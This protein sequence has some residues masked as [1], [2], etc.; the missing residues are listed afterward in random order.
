MG[1]V[2]YV[3]NHWNDMISSI[4]IRPWKLPNVEKIKLCVTL[5]EDAHY[6]GRSRR[7][8]NDVHW[9]SKSWNDEV[10]SLKLNCYDCSVIL[11]EHMKHKGNFK[12]FMDDVS[13]VGKWWNDRT[14]SIKLVHGRHPNYEGSCVDPGERKAYNAILWIP[15]FSTV[16]SL[17]SSAV[18]GGKGCD[19]VAKE[20]AIDMGIWFGD[21]HSSSANRGRCWS[22]SE[23][24]ALGGFSRKV[25]I[26]YS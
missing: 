22:R 12:A 10:S 14:S 2:P 19:S 23:G 21:G 18:Y 8:C 9:F 25:R 11:Y 6:R 5:Y 16:Y 7:E 24:R 20:R 13:Y 4:Q 1:D 26:G 17:I 3:G 15:L